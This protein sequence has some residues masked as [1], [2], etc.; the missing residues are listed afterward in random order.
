MRPRAYYW[1]NLPQRRARSSPQKSQR[2]FRKTGEE[3]RAFLTARAGGVDQPL[4]AV[5]KVQA[6]CFKTR[7]A[8]HLKTTKKKGKT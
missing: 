3:E 6:C 2:S 7:D 4:L 5:A 1:K 8:P